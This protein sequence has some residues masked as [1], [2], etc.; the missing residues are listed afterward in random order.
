MQFGFIPG[1]GTADAIFI[2]CV[3]LEDS[4]HRKVLWWAMRRV[5]VEEWVILAVKSMPGNPKS[6]V[7][8]NGSFS[9][10]FNMKVGVH[11]GAVLSPLLFIIFMEAL[12]REFKVSNPWE[13][14][15]AYDLV[16]MA[17]T[18]ENLKKKLAN[19][20]DNI[21]AK[22]LRVNFIKTKLCSKH[23]STAKSDPG[24]WSCS[25]CHKGVCSNSIFCQS[26]N[27]WVHKRC[28]KIKE[29]SKVVSA[30]FLLVCF[31]CSKES[32]WERMR[33]SKI[34]ERLKVVSATFLLVCFVHLKE[35]TWERRKNVFYFTSKALL[36]LEI[37]RFKHFGYSNMASSDAQ[38][39]NTKHVLLNKLGSKRSLVVKFG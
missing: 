1:W 7:H 39:W 23:N 35:S 29:R 2:L 6:C 21:K 10:E 3:D 31:V 32:T 38:G 16:L 15:Y 4:E 14:L 20:K 37:I 8:V 22:G 17:E 36:V 28:S 25:I 12:S 34:K 19:W 33:C 27:H 5:G 13:L 9:D 26:C 18:L 24:K 11:Q 30:T